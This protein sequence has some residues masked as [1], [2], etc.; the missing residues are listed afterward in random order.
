MAHKVWTL[1]EL[2]YLREAYKNKSVRQIAK[3]MGLKPGQVDGALNRHGI[4]SGRNGR[5]QKGVQVWNK[6]VYCRFSQKS[7]FKK[8]HQPHNTKFDGAISWRRGGLTHGRIIK[9]QYL[10]I[11]SGKWVLLHRHIWEQAN[12]PIPTN[13][14]VI[15]KDKDTSNCSLSN[16]ELITTR[17]NALRNVNRE[18]AKAKLK[19]T[20]RIE[21][22]RRDYGLPPKT[23]HGK[24]INSLTPL[25]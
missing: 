11:S 6:G 2:E 9:Y 16:L 25:N 15:F 22:L 12:G 20:W 10:R 7:E 8:G 17:E 3:E 19:E 18:K 24:K 21:K 5:F 23:G 14:L 4:A 13:M 1:K